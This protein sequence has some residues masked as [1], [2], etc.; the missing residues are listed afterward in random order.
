MVAKVLLVQKV[1]NGGNL[2]RTTRVFKRNL[3]LSVLH[4]VVIWVGCNLVKKLKVVELL[5]R[6]TKSRRLKSRIFFD[7]LD[8][9]LLLMLRA[10]YVVD[11]VVRSK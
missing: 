5:L 3:L 10:L 11:L 8:L 4:V 9:A 2:Q 1:L 7:G 6:V